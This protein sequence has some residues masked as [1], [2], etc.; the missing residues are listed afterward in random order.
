LTFH[1][2]ES[3]NFHFSSSYGLSL[4]HVTLFNHALLLTSLHDMRHMYLGQFVKLTK[5][6]IHSFLALG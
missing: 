3:K 4:L 6:T 2:S 1:A 5:R